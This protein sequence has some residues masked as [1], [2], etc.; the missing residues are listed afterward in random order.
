VRRPG[1]L[2]QR[3][4]LTGKPLLLLLRPPLTR[5][6]A[7][8]LLVN[9]VA[10]EGNVV[11]EDL[12]LVVMDLVLLV[13]SVHLVKKAKQKTGSTKFMDVA[14]DVVLLVETVLLTGVDV[15]VDQGHLQPTTGLMLMR[16]RKK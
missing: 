2:R 11:V 5:R 8:L 4:R 10:V 13:L 15:A 3:K 16:L 7:L 1:K 9:V 6:L 14:A 12:A